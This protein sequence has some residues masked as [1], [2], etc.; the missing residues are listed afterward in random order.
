MSSGLLILA[1]LATTVIK[2]GSLVTVNIRGGLAGSCT[3]VLLTRHH[4]LAPQQCE[5]GQVHRRKTTRQA[6]DN[7]TATTIS[8]F[9]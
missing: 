6:P 9:V 5:G 8:L 1:L 2:V 4:L 3:G 7:L